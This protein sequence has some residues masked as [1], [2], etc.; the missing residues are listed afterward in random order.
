M[1]GAL[2]LQ[3]FNVSTKAGKLESFFF[4][5]VCCVRADENVCGVC[6]C[7]C[8]LGPIISHRTRES[9]HPAHAPTTHLLYVPASGSLL[10]RSHVTSRFA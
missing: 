10:Q 5:L 3:N 1:A 9:H 6:V 8:F 7:V 2:V 4:L